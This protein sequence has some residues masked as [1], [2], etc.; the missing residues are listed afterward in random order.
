MKKFAICSV[1]SLILLSLADPSYAYLDPGSGS[2]IWQSIL[3]G[4]AGAAIFFK[5]FW[6]KLTTIF[7]SADKK[8]RNSEQ[9]DIEK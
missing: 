1:V 4:L 5:F 3:A 2:M 8:K 6:H 7:G 9:S